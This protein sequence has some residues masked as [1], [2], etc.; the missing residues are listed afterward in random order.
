MAALV[1]LFLLRPGAERLKSR[2][3][4]SLSQSIGR[5]VDI[6]SV[7]IQFLPPAF[8]LNDLRV[9]DDAA[10]SN[11][12]IL[13]AA[14]VTARIR[15]RSLVRGQLELARLE[16]TDPSL[17]L[18]RNAA[19]GWNVQAILERSVHA[20]TAPTAAMAHSDRTAFP[21]IEATGARV[22]FKFGVEKKPYAL[23]NADLSLW[24]DSDNSMSIRLKGVPLRTDL[25][26]SDTGTLRME[27]TWQRAPKLSEAPIRMTAQWEGGQLGQ[28]SRL[29]TGMDRGWRGDVAMQA[30]VQGTPDDLVVALDGS[31]ADF[32][33]YD[34]ATGSALGLAARCTGHYN[35]GS[36]TLSNGE[37]SSSVGKGVIRVQGGGDGG[38]VEL[39]GKAEAVPMAQIAE[40]VRRAK[41]NLAG[42]LTAAGVLNAEFA[43]NKSGTAG[44]LEG[45]GKIQGLHLASAANDADFDFGDVALAVASGVES[46]RA[47]KSSIREAAWIAATS[48][49]RLDVG[50]ISLP[51]GG[52]VPV[53][54]AARITARDYELA[55]RGEATV[56]KAV[57][58]ARVLGL[59][60]PASEM[61]GLADGSV[62]IAGPWLGSGANPGFEAPAITGTAK[63]RQVKLA[64]AGR[65]V[66]IISADVTFQRERTH[67]SSIE[68][69]AAGTHWT[70]TVDRPRGCTADKC[71]M[72][73]DL[74]A[75]EIDPGRIRAWVAPATTKL[76][77]YAFLQSS[78]HAN[79]AM[80]SF[81]AAGKVEAKRVLWRQWNA[82]DATAQVELGDGK[83]TVSHLKAS[84][85][86]GVHLGT[87]TA[88]YSTKAPVVEGKGTFS[89]VRFAEFKKLLH[90][91]RLASETGNAAYEI[92]ATGSGPAGADFKVSGSATLGRQRCE[93]SG[94]MADPIV[95][96]LDK[97]LE[98]RSADDAGPQR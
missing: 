93:I 87:W 9:F 1:L 16:L 51:L 44:K 33:R 53:T 38:S 47:G 89:G 81:R 55:M 26:I 97:Q 18:V 43:Y 23:T 19:G 42:D 76:P 85:F 30:E 58:L 20:S 60:A 21:Y 14:E 80:S 45:A 67:I 98:A 71:A 90:D 78:P 2:I 79:T 70:G 73:F 3:V 75:N 50:P 48:A 8:E 54:L 17:N 62:D 68:A 96:A 88:D 46:G 57:R 35:F 28:L 86:G 69:E 31:L 13:R 94:T 64:W 61:Q 49:A 5:P 24:Q 82:T 27:G 65:P 95:H 32:R 25:S 91:D 29:F 39:A 41:S 63:L 10:Y 59:P 83:L 56:S 11:E 12:P 84:I 37:C 74:T 72:E 66:E 7:H 15:L 34:I 40:L 22:N 52:K 4:R 36:H 6:Q 77:W 92:K